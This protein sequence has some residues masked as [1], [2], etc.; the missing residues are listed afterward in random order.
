MS[1]KVAVIGVGNSKFGKRDDVSIR[2]L[3]WEA[4]QESLNDAGLTL[5]DIDLTIIGSTAYRGVEIYPAPVVAEY[6]GLVGKAPIR[7]E[8]ACATGSAAALNA[9]MAIRSGLAK[10]VLAIGVDKM[11]E[12]GTATSLA[13]GGRGGNYQ[14]EFHLYGT[15][16][17][18]YYALYA[19]RHMALYGTTEEDMALAS[20][21]AHKYALSNEKAHLRKSISV[22]DVLKSRVISSPLKLLDCSPISDGA[23]AVIFASEEVAK[24]ITDA[25][26]WIKGVGYS[27]DTSSLASRGEW[28][29][30]RSARE[31]ANNAYSMAGIVPADV[32]YATVHDC[33]SIAEIIAYEDLGFAERGKGVSLLREGQTEKGGKVGT[34]LFGG[35][36]A[37]GHPLGATGL[38]MIYEIT[39]QMRDE[40]GSVQHQFK[41]YIAL[42]HN[43]GGTGH[44][45]YVFVYSR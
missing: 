3:S 18:T 30:L 28:T 16:F 15:T 40:A 31:A 29:S 21:K 39:K 19:R 1:S 45:A 11:T 12:V 14:Y 35:L 7:V 20:V 37:K 41:K 22:D 5:Q 34:N 33:F 44:Y 24:K 17:P 27:S 23:A 6:N 25:P 36:K 13:I 42:S 9:Y 8:A 26:V 10:I 43:V 2:E 32:E 38:S 4:V